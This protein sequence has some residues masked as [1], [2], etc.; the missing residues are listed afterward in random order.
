MRG[1]SR[2]AEAATAVGAC[3]LWARHRRALFHA[4]FLGPHPV[5]TSAPG[6]PRAHMVDGMDRHAKERRLIEVVDLHRDGYLPRS[7]RHQHPLAVLPAQGPQQELPPVLRHHQHPG[8]R[9]N[10]AIDHQQVAIEHAMGA[11]P[12]AGDPHVE[13]ADRPG[14]QQGIEI[15]RLAAGGAA[16]GQGLIQGDVVEDGGRADRTGVLGRPGCRLGGS[17]HRRERR[18]AASAPWHHQRDALV[19]QHLPLADRIAATFHRRYAELV[20]LDD[21]R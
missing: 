18:P 5:P 1:S 11:Q 16:E 21:L 2:G 7:H 10:G 15:E 3:S 13:G 8:A 12:V 6:F 4:P 9:G 19:R 20:E 17:Q 14:R